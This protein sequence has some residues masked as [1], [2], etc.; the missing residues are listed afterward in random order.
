M[1]IQETGG[2]VEVAAID[3]VTS[4]GSIGGE[5][6]LQTAEDVKQ[7]LERVVAAV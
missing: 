7:K 4:I 6:L 5:A 1:I 2:S 3:P